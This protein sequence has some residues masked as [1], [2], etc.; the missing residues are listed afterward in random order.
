MKR[1]ALTIALVLTALMTP[2][3]T[4]TANAHSAASQPQK[5]SE[6]HTLVALWK[7]FYKAQDADLPQDQAKALEA[8]KQEAR[9]KH[10]AWDFYDA[11]TRY[12]QVRSSINWKDRESLNKAM[13]QEIA[14]FAEPVLIFYHTVRNYSGSRPGEYVEQ[15]K[16]A[17]QASYN[18]EFHDRDGSYCRAIYSPVL[19][20]TVKNDYEYCLWSLFHSGRPSK[21]DDYYDEAYPEEAFIEYTEDAKYV[22]KTGYDRM[23]NYIEEYEGKAVT[24]MARQ[25]RLNYEFGNLR[26]SKLASSQRFRELRAACDEFENDRKKFTGSEKLIADCCTGVKDMINSL[27]AKEISAGIKD[28]ILTL[29]L[30]NVS[31]VALKIQG[32]KK[33][34]F[35]KSIPNKTASYYV[36]DTVTYK[37]PDIDDGLYT[38]ICKSGNAEEKVE[39]AKYT[40]SI[41]LRAESRGYGVY[42]ADYVTGEPVK[43]CNLLLTDADGTQ[44]ATASGVS[45]DG[46]TLLPESLGAFFRDGYRRMRL[47][48]S[49]KDASGRLR[50]SILISLDTRNRVEDT[51]DSNPE[52]HRALLITDRTAFNPGET[53]HFKGICYIG[54]YE[55]SLSPAG[56]KVTV[57]LYDPQGNMLSEKELTTNEFGSVDG[58]FE[59]VGGTRGGLY[60]LRLKRNGSTLCHRSLRVDEFVLPTFD[61]SWDR[62]TNLYLM[63]DEITFSGRLAAYSGHSLGSARATY[64]I[65]NYSKNS[66]FSGDLEL[67]S[68][69]RFKIQFPSDDSRYGQ[70]YIIKI[71][72]TDAT[73]ETLTFDHSAYVH[74][75][76]PLN[77]SLANRT[78]GRYTVPEGRGNGYNMS[79]WI[80]G[81]D[82][83]RVTFGFGGLERKGLK[84]KYELISDKTGKAVRSGN[85]VPG[86]EVAI[87]LRGLPSGLYKLE[88]LAT[89]VKASGTKIEESRTATI[90]KASETDTVLDMDVTSFFME[91][92][93]SEPGKTDLSLQIGA[94]NGPVWAVVELFGSGSVL[95]D[96]QIVKLEGVRG[97]TGSLKTIRYDRR[98][99]WPESLTIKVLWFRDGGSFQYTRN[100]K[101][102]VPVRYVP[103]EFT[104]FRESVR[105][106][107]E[108]SLLIKTLPGM[109]CAAT[110]FDKATETI[111]S[112]Y[113]HQVIPSRRPVPTVSYNVACGTNSGIYNILYSIEDGA[114]PVYRASALAKSSNEAA[115]MMMAEEAADVAVYDTVAQAAEPEQ[116]PAVRENFGAT[117]A[118][119]P[120]LRSGEDGEMELRI[121][122]SDRLSTY[123]VQ[124]FAHG[125]GMQ[126]AALRREMQVT[127][128]VKISLVEPQFL[129]EGDRYVVRVTLASTLEAPVEGRIAL[130]FCNGDDYRTSPVLA[131]R[132][133]QIKLDAGATAPWYTEFTVPEGIETLGVFVKF[134]ADD[135][136]LASDAM[137]VKIPVRK[138]VQTLTEAHSALL[139]AGADKDA[140]VKEL[141]SLFVNLDASQLEPRERSILDMVR[142]AIPDKVEPASDNVL[143]LTEAYYSNIL[144]RRLGAP[145]LDDDGLAE[146]LSKIAACQNAGGGISWFEGMEASPLITATI[147]QRIAAMPDAD[148]SAINIE[149]AVKYLDSNYFGV[150]GRPWW[151]GSISLENYL[152]T[153]ALFPSVPFESRSGKDFR[154]FKKEAKDYL[155][156]SGKR[157]LNANILGKARRLRTLQLLL[158]HPD[159][160]TLAKAWGITL[161]SKVEKSFDAD[162]KSLLQ[163]AV[164]HRSGGCYYPNAV[165]PWRGLLES[166]VYAHSLLCALLDTT[167]EQGR[168]TAEGIRLWLMVQKE[169]QH[170]ENDS[171]YLEAI[172]SVLRGTPETLATRVVL[173]SGSFTKPFTEVKAAGN[174]Y[175][176]ERSFSVNGKPLDEGDILKVGDKVTATYAIWSE[177]NRSFVR[178]TVPRPASLRPVKQLSGSYGWW[179][180]PISISGWTFSPQGYRNVLA[181]KTEYW[182]DSYPE[183]KTSV[184]EEFYV[185]QE[186]AFQ[187]PAVEIESLYA[188]H[189][190]ANDAGRGP[191]ESK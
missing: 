179:L 1:F 165:M 69:G 99:E 10:L 124:L 114:A 42:V 136:A 22:N 138:P 115:P 100:V 141:R 21:I 38:V 77:L 39:W 174:G 2:A 8:I 18:P 13:E 127:I 12:V 7:T 82:E 102:P 169:T 173:L 14:D 53:V 144:A 184:T 80:V 95:L 66:V 24:L 163:Y 147:L 146:I 68:D 117:M 35:E 153:R 108:C 41:A 119:E 161:R 150:K 172:A 43:R 181:D 123:I 81:D 148:L 167:T 59:L 134:A 78:E 103:L 109:E 90:V 67:S 63:G 171:A 71:T 15:N 155:V 60:D 110:I 76:L 177:E 57:Q 131:T 183:E 86:S 34:V 55:Y 72:V 65:G 122:G 129:Y 3:E 97:R 140:L 31:T 118:W 187:T 175:T 46:F 73:G 132:T 51:G 166:E 113:W 93:S 40:L 159:G 26:N 143:C 52:V 188:P 20:K 162:V 48:A 32:P 25:Y 64:E 85:P 105:P 54:T 120:Y 156:P 126:N 178:L 96:K 70:M 29:H 190:R 176:V 151:C 37:L 135:D 28:G 185:T 112:N 125:E 145:G 182:F 157:G 133:A 168:Q 27:D 180:R 98:P 87:D 91:P 75:D 88:A 6:G 104:R 191:L 5:D 164:E 74:G 137:F 23:A 45:L 61:I 16:A 33:T 9:T 130:R 17:L 83:A 107:E 149:A 62:D 19:R 186:G 36:R 92:G 116:E 49:F 56:S 47:S 4:Q 121:K 142:E 30:R 139:K 94:T 158:Q 154:E 152:L 101:L 58:S 160:K 11:A 128:P 79:R 111:S 106:G 50:S 89:A 44:L 84:V 189:Y 170:W